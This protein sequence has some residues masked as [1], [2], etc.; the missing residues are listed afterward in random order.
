VGMV[1]AFQ[2]VA[3]VRELVDPSLLASG[4]WEALITTVGGLFVG[5]PALVLHHLYQNRLKSVAFSMK[6]YAEEIYS[7]TRGTR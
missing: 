4:I 1:G 6:H 2:K 3:V 7:M 5:I